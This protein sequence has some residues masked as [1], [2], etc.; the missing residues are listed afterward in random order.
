M[1]D[2]LEAWLADIDLDDYHG[3]LQKMGVKKVKH[4]R[5]VQKEHL[6]K[7]G[8]LELEVPR[9]LEKRQETFRDEKPL[10]LSVP[11]S[12]TVGVHMPTTSFGHKW[13]DIPQSSLVKEYSDVWY[14]EP[15]NFKQRASNSFILKMCSAAHWRFST[16]KSLY[17]WARMER[18][19]RWN[20]LLTLAEPEELTEDTRY[21]KDQC[22]TIRLADLDSSYMDV[23]ALLKQDIDAH[24]RKQTRLNSYTDQLACLATWSQFRGHEK[25]QPKSRG[26]ERPDWPERRRR[27][28][29]ETE[30]EG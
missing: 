19:A 5:Q 6:I 28:L 17:S 20:A 2:E 30:K 7:I 12:P 18:D 4:L 8:M 21:F 10:N 9:F 27:I 26:S 1:S 24:Q 29:G 3:A 11:P 15:Q 16:K 23:T 13:H 22:I 25:N 14:E